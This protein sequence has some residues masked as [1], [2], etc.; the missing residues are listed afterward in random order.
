VRANGA[1][2]KFLFVA[3]TGGH[4]SQ[5]L[6]LSVAMDAC[7]DSLWITFRTPQSE[8][9][10]EGR[11]VVYVP[12]VRSRD[13]LGVLRAARV[14]RRLLS[15]ERFDRVVSTGAA[16]AVSAL[17]LAR[18]RRIPTLYIESV[19]RVH[20]PSL[21]GRIIAATRAAAL[22]TQHAS[23]AGGRWKVHPS[24]FG[25]Y[26]AEPRAQIERPRLLVTVGTI[27]GYRFDSVIDAVLASGLADERTV[28]QLGDS[29]REGLPGRAVDQLE[30]AEFTRIAQEADVVV[31]HAGVG[32][33]LE[34][35]ELGIY[36][37]L[38]PRRHGRREHVD[39]HQR[40]IAGLVEGMGVARVVEADE[41]SPGDLIAASGFV[42]RHGEAAV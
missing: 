33:V 21:T 32:T 19:S 1:T 14:V 30:S 24:V 25:T 10:L 40:Q 8:S 23:W 20:G 22:R 2:V 39:D 34:L 3:S 16:L 18:L 27:K 9:L 17:P 42:V 4:L 11:R 38:V 29:L 15:S 12:Y 6:R 13:I 41:L 37:V 26:F 28:W 7:P 5:L 36:P 31:S 35:L